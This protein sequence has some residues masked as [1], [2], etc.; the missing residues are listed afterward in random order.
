MELAFVVLM[1]CVLS[2]CFVISLI[3]TAHKLREI[4][5]ETNA[6]LYF[7]LDELQKEGRLDGYMMN[8]D[9]MKKPKFNSD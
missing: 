2:L 7:K 9:K 5:T 4:H 1:F 3:V 6:L 8:P